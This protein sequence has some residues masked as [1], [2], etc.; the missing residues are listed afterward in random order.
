MNY[1]NTKTSIKKAPI[2]YGEQYITTNMP[3]IYFIL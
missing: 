1:L 2:I 3:I